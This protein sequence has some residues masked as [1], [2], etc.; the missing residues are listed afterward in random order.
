MKELGV[1]PR[2]AKISLEILT[3]D[4]M[5]EPLD[6]D[7]PVVAKINKQSAD[8]VEEV[9]SVTLKTLNNGVSHAEEYVLSNSLALGPYEIDYEVVI[10]GKEHHRTELFILEE[11][12]TQDDPLTENEEDEKEKYADKAGYIMPPEFQVESELEVKGNTV[13][14]TLS[15]DF[16]PNHSYHLIVTEDVKTLGGEVKLDSNY[17]MHFTS[18]YSPLYATPLEVRSILKD[19]F[20]YYNLKDIYEAIRDAGQK[21]HQMLRLPANASQAGFQLIQENDDSYFPAM[22]YSSY[23]AANQLLNQLIIKLLYTS[24]SE[25]GSTSIIDREGSDDSF[26]LGDFQVSK[27]SDQ[28]GG[29]STQ[30]GEPPETAVLKR[31][32]AANEIELK[33][34]QDALMGRNARGY[35]SPISATSRGG[36]TAPGSRD[37]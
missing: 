7:S 37:I 22:K 25:D 8:G 35:A 33:F 18:E 34:W 13:E 10:D 12:V 6:I 1:L 31:L 17:E 23:Q 21:A 26:V 20:H 14:I 15:S 24:K 36:V 29:Q 3:K 19:V 27:K 2:K 28:Q 16:K 30:N 4:A 9:D 11:E 32:V 5:G